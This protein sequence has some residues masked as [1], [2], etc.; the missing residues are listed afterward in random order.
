M[1]MQMYGVSRETFEKLRYQWV[2][3]ATA[4]Q[5][6]A[7]LG[8]TEKQVHDA[9]SRMKLTK[10][11][12]PG[13]EHIKTSGF[14]TGDHRRK[15]ERFKKLRIRYV[16]GREP[17]ERLAAEA[18]MAPGSLHRTWSEL[19]LTG[20]FPIRNRK[21]REGSHAVFGAYRQ[22]KISSTEGAEILGIPTSTFHDRVRQLGYHRPKEIK[23]VDRKKPVQDRARLERLFKYARHEVVERGRSWKSVT[24]DLV[25]A[26][27]WMGSDKA[28]RTA[29]YRW[30]ARVS[31][32]PWNPNNTKKK[33]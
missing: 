6:A 14:T 24:K 21:M 29:S 10:I 25:D 18:K 30:W 7:P 17:L 22:G 12:R 4:A 13:T 23:R 3:G 19:G 9:W 5:L 31:N 8:L 26:K 15:R 20:E 1:K 27:K 28:L 32:T 33:K 2:E 16:R 11:R